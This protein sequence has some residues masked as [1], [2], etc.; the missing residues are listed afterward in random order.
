M[1]DYRLENA[2]ADLD[3]VYVENE[4]DRKT[5]SGVNRA[6]ERLRNSTARYYENDINLKDDDIGNIIFEYENLLNA[7][8][9][10]IKEG[11]NYTDTGFGQ[12]RLHCVK[13]IRALVSEDLRALQEALALDE[14]GRTLQKVIEE[15]RS[16]SAEVMEGE[17]INTVGGAMS[18]RIPVRLTMEDGTVEEGFF[19]ESYTVD[20]YETTMAKALQEAEKKYEKDSTEERIARNIYSLPQAEL[21]EL[22]DDLYNP[23]KD[24]LENKEMAAEFFKFP[25]SVSSTDKAIKKL[26][27]S[28]KEELMKTENIELR[29]HYYEILNDAFKKYTHYNLNHGMA[30]IPAGQ[31]IDKRNTAMSSIA[32][33]FDMGG[34]IAGARNFKLKINGVEKTGTF[35]QKAKGNDISHLDEKN[36]M[37]SVGKRK[38]FSGVDSIELKRQLSDLQVLDYICGNK[39]RH[40]G[41]M[42]YRTEGGAITGITGIDNDMSF[43]K[44]VKADDSEIEKLVDPENMRIM[45]ENTARKILETKP[46]TLDLILKDMNFTGEEMDACKKRLKKL[47]DQLTADIKWKKDK[48]ATKLKSGRILVVPDSEFDKYDIEHL[49]NRNPAHENNKNYFERMMEL[50]KNLAYRFESKKFD[51]P[52]KAIKYINAKAEKGSLNFM[53]EEPITNID[54]E[55]TAQSVAEA[56]RLFDNMGGKLYGKDTGHYEWMKKSVGQLNTYFENLKQQHPGGKAVDIPSKDAVKLETLFR[57]IRIAGDNYVKTHPNPW[58]PQGKRRREMGVAMSGL[59]VTAAVSTVPEAGKEPGRKTVHVKHT[60]IDKLVEKQKKIDS[61]NSVSDKKKTAKKAAVSQTTNQKKSGTLKRS[62]SVVKPKTPVM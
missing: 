33:Y 42:L 6:I 8:D 28:L 3:A 54:L 18:S 53:K 27:P 49:A 44:K 59:K 34:M 25:G 9:D 7:C 38:D 51:K 16:I 45:R 26:D 48:G 29:R 11:K 1:P 30:E 52:E 5:L 31:R 39:D 62:N 50:K 36:G 32:H 41:N 2:I 22:Y 58:T 20:D 15:G 17:S 19:T 60:D 57:Q 35:Q 55:K 24:T 14:K 10:Y 43:G 13:A 46:E 61:Q 4:D 56:K 37:W 47:Q 12:G 40:S 23:V 21:F